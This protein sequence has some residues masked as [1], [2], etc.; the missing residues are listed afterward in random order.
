MRAALP[1]ESRRAWSEAIT[2]HALAW[3]VLERATSVMAYVSVSS[4]VETRALLVA[5]LARGK[6]LL[7]PRC[8][9]GGRMDAVEITSLDRLV[10]G[11]LGIPEP[12]AAL[13][14]ADKRSI[15]LILAPGLLFDLSG[16]RMGQGAG[17]YDRFLADYQGETC[18]LCFSA[19][20]QPLAPAPHD[21]PVGALIMETGLFVCKG[22]TLDG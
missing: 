21:M 19:Q 15:D 10:P 9:G 7:L 8:H 6:R 3:D 17:Y 5:L 14:A 20:I 1:G 2:A 4:E 16:N 13:P 11:R 12:D 18:G 22:G